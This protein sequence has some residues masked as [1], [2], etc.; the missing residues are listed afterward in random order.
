MAESSSKMSS[1]EKHGFIF[2]DFRDEK[3]IQISESE[4]TTYIQVN[5]GYEIYEILEPK[6]WPPYC[7][8]FHP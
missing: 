8:R 6:L 4:T 7:G 5:K 3:N 2:P 1:K